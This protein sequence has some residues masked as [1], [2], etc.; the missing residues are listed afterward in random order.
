MVRQIGGGVHQRLL[1]NLTNVGLKQVARFN[2]AL[3]IVSIMLIHL[4]CSLAVKTLTNDDLFV[5]V[6]IGHEIAIIING[7]TIEPEN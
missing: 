6:M 2:V 4:I 7:S 5:C 3:I 1:C